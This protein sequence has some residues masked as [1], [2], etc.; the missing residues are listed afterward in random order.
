MWCLLHCY[1]QVSS[2]RMVLY[3]WW[4]TH[5]LWTFSGTDISTAVITESGVAIFNKVSPLR[6]SIFGLTCDLLT[7]NRIF[8][9]SLTISIAC[10]VKTVKSPHHYRD[11]PFDSEI[12]TKSIISVENDT[13]V[14]TGT[15]YGVCNTHSQVHIISET[16]GLGNKAWS[17][18]IYFIWFY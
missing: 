2:T 16:L 17:P 8:L 7:P 15:L 10:T 13:D 14:W 4:L 6:L 1:I 12:N 9:S 5:H 11:W 18:C 3:L